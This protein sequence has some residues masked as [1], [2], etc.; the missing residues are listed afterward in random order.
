MTNALP[1]NQSLSHPLRLLLNAICFVHMWYVPGNSGKHLGVSQLDL[2]RPRF[3]R[4][5]FVRE[6]V[7]IRF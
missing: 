5:P 6:T 2:A 7:L 3:V 4:A 1:I